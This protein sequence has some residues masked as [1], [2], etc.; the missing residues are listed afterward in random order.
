M[1]SPPDSDLPAWTPMA[2]LAAC[3]AAALYFWFDPLGAGERTS[4]PPAVKPAYY[5]TT[6]VRGRLKTALMTEGTPCGTCHDSMDPPAVDP[7]KR[8]T[9][10]SQIVLRHGAN[11]R[12]FNC[13]NSG[14]RDFFSG[15]GGEPIP[16]SRVETLCAKCHGPHYRDWQQGAHGRRNGYWNTAM[17]ERK[18]QV[19][20]VCHDPHW[21]VFKP[22]R[23]AP[24]PRTLRVTASAEEH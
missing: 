14:K 22:L 10:H 20:I 3:I 6:P 13:H 21:P 5:D 4:E 18:T 24:A 12:C 19:C 1:G 15:F 9:F 7:S 11:V 17:G 23:A 8:G 16:Y 2:A